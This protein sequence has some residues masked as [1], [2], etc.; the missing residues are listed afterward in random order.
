MMMWWR[1]CLYI[2]EGRPSHVIFLKSWAT[3]INLRGHA[4]SKQQCS[5]GYCRDYFSGSEILLD[6]MCCG[7]KI[8]TRYTIMRK[9]RH[10]L[11]VVKCST[12][13]HAVCAKWTSEKH[14]QHN[15]KIEK[16]MKCCTADVHQYL[17]WKLYSKIFRCCLA[18]LKKQWKSKATKKRGRICMLAT[19][20]L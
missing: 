17:M 2:H 19:I 20:T 18:P 13:Q 10:V 12:P 11:T 1:S 15:K 7:R 6:T 5:F 9:Q 14:T 4:I 8:S 16:T 3:D